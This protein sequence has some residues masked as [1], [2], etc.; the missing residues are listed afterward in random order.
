MP[1]P[2]DPIEDDAPIA[3]LANGVDWG[4]GGVLPA[5]T[6]QDLKHVDE[7]G[8]AVRSRQLSTSSFAVI[9]EA[10]TLLVPERAVTT[11]AN[12]ARS[13]SA[14]SLGDRVILV[15]ADDHDGNY[16]LYLQILMQ[17]STC[18]S[19]ERDSASAPATP[20]TQSLRSGRT[21]TSACCTMTGRAALGSRISWA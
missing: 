14:L 19:R 17:I 13:F 7:D 20:C 11:G 5:I 2:V 12:F 8:D 6:S 18:C 3:P 21:A 15:W 1:S 10:G 4:S 16:D 9:D